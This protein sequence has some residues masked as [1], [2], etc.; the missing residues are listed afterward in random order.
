MKRIDYRKKYRAYY[1][2]PSDTVQE[3]TIPRMQFVM[4]DGKGATESPEGL[5]EFQNAIQALYGI[6]YT[7]KMGRKKSGIGPDYTV[8][9]LEGMWWMSK[10][11]EFD[12]SRPSDWRWTL[13]IFQPDFITQDDFQSALDKLKKKKPNLTLD[14]LRLDTF[15]EDRVIQL[16]HI[17]QYDQEAAD[18][19]KLTDYAKEK[20]YGFR[21]KH[22]EIYLGDPRRTNPEKLKTVLRYAVSE[23]TG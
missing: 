18:I 1:S 11:N 19:K 4:I 13:M 12:A 16:M 8:G 2:P 9:P 5:T 20:G 15:E 23:A 22:H 3:T 10:G 14:S 7:L 17:G 6:T 21:G